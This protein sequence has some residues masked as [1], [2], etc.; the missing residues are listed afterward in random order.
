MFLSAMEISKLDQY[1]IKINI[2]LSEQLQ[3]DKF[4]PR[5]FVSLLLCLRSMY[6]LVIRPVIPLLLNRLE[7]RIYN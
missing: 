6:E 5:L 4:Y 3:L 7:E 1:L 2:F